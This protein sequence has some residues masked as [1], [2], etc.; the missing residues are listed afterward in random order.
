MGLL[1][2]TSKGEVS[3]QMKCK[4][5]NLTGWIHFLLPNRIIV[6]KSSFANCQHT[7]FPA[8]TSKDA[9]YEHATYKNHD[10]RLIEVA[11]ENGSQ[12]AGNVLLYVYV[13]NWGSQWKRLPNSRQCVCYYMCMW[14]TEVA[15]ENGSNTARRSVEMSWGVVKNPN[16]CGILMIRHSQLLGHEL[17]IHLVVDLA[18]LGK[19]HQRHGMS[20]DAE[21][22]PLLRNIQ[23][24]RFI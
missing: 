6:L 1:Y 4:S 24:A 23:T 3:S 11:N 2:A 22:H 21:D 5:R 20:M 9:T 8:N 19:S 17:G 16:R 14:L 15:N 12:T 18:Y 13:T 10:T 7:L